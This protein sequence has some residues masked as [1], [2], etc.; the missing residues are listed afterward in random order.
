[1]PNLAGTLLFGLLLSAED[2]QV[3]FGLLVVWFEIKDRQQGIFGGLSVLA[4]LEKGVTAQ[5]PRLDPVGER[6][7]RPA[8]VEAVLSGSARATARRSF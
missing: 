8:H 3:V 2:Q 7:D 6:L 4:F 5:Q 1:M